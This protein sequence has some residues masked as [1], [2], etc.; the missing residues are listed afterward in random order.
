MRKILINYYPINK[1]WF[2]C[3]GKEIRYSFRALKSFF[4]HGKV[5]RVLA[6]PELPG[7]RAIISKITGHQKW[8]IT[9][10]PKKKIIFAIS[11]KDATIRDVPQVLKKLSSEIKV[12][13]L[14]NDNILKTYVEEYFYEAFG[15]RTRIDPQ[16]HHGKAVCKS[17]YNATHSGTIVDC[18]V[19]EPEKDCIYQI[20]IDNRTEEG[21]FE[22]IRVPVI[23]K[24]IPYVYIKLKEEPA[25]FETRA[26]KVLLEETGKYITDDEHEKILKFTASIGLDF[27]EIDV[28]RNRTDGKLYIVDVNNTPYGPPANLADVDA[29]QAV[30]MQAEKLVALLKQ[31]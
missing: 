13:N 30:R 22:D 5:L 15:Y 23:G 26:Q 20:V 24:T 25:R 14:Y 27:G 31:R 21:F 16:L 9:N 17:E 3:F 11:W 1:S 29:K 2:E 4:R 18:P 8:I 10:N 12:L 7:S 28:L 6:Y 19:A